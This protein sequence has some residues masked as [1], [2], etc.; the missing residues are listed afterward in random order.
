MFLSALDNIALD[1][2]S[3]PTFAPGSFMLPWANS[4]AVVLGLFAFSSKQ[5]WL[6]PW[7]FAAGYAVLL[8]VFVKTTK[9]WRDPVN[10]LCL[11]LIIGSLRFF[12]S[13]LLFMAGAEPP[14]NVS[15]YRVATGNRPMRWR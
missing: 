15:V 3:S 6:L 14:E 9:V 11:V 1:A 12:C 2:K 8:S 13:G 5:D 7:F 4:C 10:P